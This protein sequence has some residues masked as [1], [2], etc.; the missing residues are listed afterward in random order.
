VVGVLARVVRDADQLGVESVH[1]LCKRQSLVSDAA[2]RERLEGSCPYAKPRFGK[3]G[4]TRYGHFR[5]M[6]AGTADGAHITNA[7]KCGP[8]KVAQFAPLRNSP[9]PGWQSRPGPGD[10]QQC[11]QELR[12]S[13]RTWQVA[14]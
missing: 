10:E 3:A 4:Q 9:W 11:D 8:L 6:L 2:P 7:P 12:T 5:L 14:R 1:E 13:T